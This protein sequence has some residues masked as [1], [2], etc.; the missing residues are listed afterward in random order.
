MSGRN[1]ETLISLLENEPHCQK[2][3]QNFYQKNPDLPHDVLRRRL[4]GFIDIFLRQ[5]FGK[6]TRLIVT[7]GINFEKQYRFIPGHNYYAN[8]LYF[9]N[10][11][12]GRIS[13]GPIKKFRVLIVGEAPSWVEASEGLNFVGDWGLLLWETLNKLQEDFH[14][15]WNDIYITNLCKCYEQNS[16]L[17]QRCI[18]RCYPHFAFELAFAQPEIVICLGSAAS[19]FFSRR[20]LKEMVREV[21]S[22]SYLAIE[23]DQLITKELKVYTAPLSAL[24]RP[25]DRFQCQ[26]ILA[27]AFES[28]YRT[29][30]KVEDLD[31]RILKSPEELN[32]LIDEILKESKSE[33][34][35]V[36]LDLE[37]HGGSPFMPAAKVL[38]LGLAYKNTGY[39]LS[40]R[41]LTLEQQKQAVSR[42]QEL[43]SPD[44]NVQII[45]FNFMADIPWLQYL[46]IDPIPKLIATLENRDKKDAFPGIFDV[47]AAYHAV[48]EMGGD[49]E[50]LAQVYLGAK[51]WSGFLAQFNTADGYGTIP[52]EYLLPYCAQD[53]LMT[54][55]L[56]DVVRLLLYNDKRTGDC[57]KPYFICL[58]SQPAY[59]EMFNTGIKVDLARLNHIVEIYNRTKL[60][61]E[62]EL[63]RELG[64]PAFN[65]N[66]SIHKICLLFG[67]QYLVRANRPNHFPCLGLTPIKTTKG[68]PWKPECKGTFEPSTDLETLRHFSKENPIVK[69]IYHLQLLAKLT[70]SILKPIA[71]DEHGQV[72]E[73]YGFF[74]FISRDGRIHPAYFPYLETRRASSSK[75]NMQNLPASQEELYREILG[76]KYP[77]SI[78][79]IFIADENYVFVSVDYVAAELL[80]L[81]LAANDDNLI[82][83]Y[84]KSLLPDDHPD[85]IDIHS[86]IAVRAFNLDCAPTKKALSEIGKLHLRS[87]A[88][89][90]IF[91]LNYG[92]SLV[93][94][95]RFFQ[96]LGLDVTLEDVE[97]IVTEIYKRYPKVKTFQAA[98]RSR[99]H[100]PGW[101]RNCFGSCRRFSPSKS[102]D[103][104]SENEREALNFLCQSTVADAI[105]VALYNAYVHP[106]KRDLGYR[107]ILQNHD[108]VLFMLPENNAEEFIRE[109]LP[110]V[111]QKNVPLYKTDLDGNRISD[112]IYHFG[113]SA[114]VKRTW[115]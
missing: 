94:C 103:A 54:L 53:C 40:L 115:A 44:A 17:R 82:S 7:H 34:Q 68:T 84:Y 88:K 107:A 45:G 30:P 61:L 101:L 81:G 69:K 12:N 1:V 58:G 23:N 79:S 18:L 5:L 56:F 114:E 6:E 26:R 76:E 59:I 49:L 19:H 87:V 36:A 64:C 46:E 72:V 93:S 96:A 110:D 43:F 97:A 21:L 60:E 13:F 38:A 105:S 2:L 106:A 37:W 63:K 24:R 29:K 71:V 22:T 10:S 32:L 92:Q 83:D 41:D 80:A 9:T 8:Y 100:Y 48:D 91:G 99:V 3:L 95:H 98:A 104:I 20:P 112:E 55:R 42:L 75:P 50:K 39:C 28:L 57:W 73:S 62:E 90:I 85:K 102:K 86:L 15:D 65:H 27:E 74:K 89:K 66:S 70:N 11:L 35:R 109:V 31:L 111:M 67:P 108:A 4:V 33:L 78:R 47:F 16:T 51:P 77:G 14:F 25:L 52:D 113:F